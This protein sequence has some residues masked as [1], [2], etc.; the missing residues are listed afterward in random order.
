MVIKS[1]DIAQ[2]GQEPTSSIDVSKL[3]GGAGGELFREI[4]PESKSYGEYGAGMS[5]RWTLENTT[6]QVTSVDTVSKWLEM[7]GDGLDVSDRYTPHFV[8]MGRTRGWGKPKRFDARADFH[9]YHDALWLNGPVHDAVLVDGRFRVC[10]FL[11]SLKNANP[12]TKIMF[13]DYKKR[14][15]YHVVEDFLK[16][17]EYAGRLALFEVPSK[18]KLDMEGIEKHIEMF[19]MV[20]D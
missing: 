1:E 10:C 12:G 6:T 13:D 14:G 17:T 7:A 8:D 19:R 11:T 3:L 5:T 18:D 4:V 16:R 9:K 20:M 15:V 2:A